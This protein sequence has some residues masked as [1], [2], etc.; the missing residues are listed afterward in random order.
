[1]QVRELC[2]R[3]NLSDTR[4][5]TGKKLSREINDIVQDSRQAKEGSI[6]L[7]RRGRETDG[8]KY[9]ADAY[10][11]GSRV[12]V[13]E[14]L[15]GK[16]KPDAVYIRV[17]NPAGMLGVI[18]AEIF[19][20]PEDKLDIYGITGTNGKTTTSFIIQ[21]LLEELEVKCG[22]IG[23]IRVDTGKEMIDTPRTTPEANQIF[24]YL[25]MMVEAG[26]RAVAMEVSSHA[27]SLERVE[28]LK[29][30]AAIFTNISRDHLDF[31]ADFA[32]Y[33]GAKLSL[34][35]YLEEKKQES[36]A[37]SPGEGNKF[38]QND[39]PGENNREND[40]SGKNEGSRK[41][42]ES[43][44]N[45]G[46]GGNIRSEANLTPGGKAFYN[47]DDNRLRRSFQ[48][49]TGPKFSFGIDGEAYYQARNISFT[50]GRLAFG[51][52]GSRFES[53]L[54]GKFNIY[55]CLASLAPLLAESYRPRDL[56][57]ALAGFP[58]VPGRF[59]QVR[60]RVGENQLSG[61]RFYAEDMGFK[62]GVR[63]AQKDKE[64]AAGDLEAEAGDSNYS[65]DSGDKVKIEDNETADRGEQDSTAKA[66]NT[67]TA[68]NTDIEDMIDD[69][70][71][72]VDYAHTPAG[73]ENVLRSVQEFH[74][75]RIISVF[76]CGGDRDKEKR[77]VMGQIGLKMSDL[78]FVTSDNPR[79]EEPG[80]II[81]DILA[82]VRKL[83]NRDNYPESAYR[84]V[85]DRE[86]AIFAAVEAAEPGDIVIIFGKGHETYQEFAGRT[87]DFDDR[88]VA[89]RALASRRE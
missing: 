73:M 7:A 8:H 6:F 41:N 9:I 60:I 53:T 35:D 79:S 86:E 4:G 19:D 48:H 22:L 50:P 3:L 21:H 57:E 54:T 62:D 44:E 88:E 70:K 65:A 2:Q 45:S 43:G 47:I 28:G 16:L 46:P 39:R 25:N 32:D 68:D 59:E 69:I 58:G 77:P 89:R 40:R 29:F 51:L 64:Q 10:R 27:L 67:E 12:F 81:E 74:S 36:N 14:Y 17:D 49:F 11:R 71:V 20:H 26:C 31:H 37:D 76:G 61:S 55:N 78:I 52:E 30:R 18:A 23:T 63:G 66:D 84:V 15:P 13:V 34:L 38:R 1:L 42:D 87:I 80:D 82:G 24:R 83:V 5:D 56:K 72:F 75:G 33:L 85:A